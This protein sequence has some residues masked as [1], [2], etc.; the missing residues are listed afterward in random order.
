[1]QSTRKTV[2]L[3]ASRSFGGVLGE[4]PQA[5]HDLVV[6]EILRIAVVV[7]RVPQNRTLELP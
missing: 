2:A 4:G 1:V 7:R 5:L 6:L 3:S